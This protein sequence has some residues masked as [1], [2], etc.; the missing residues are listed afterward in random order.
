MSFATNGNTRIY[1]ESYGEGTALVFAH[2][3]GGNASS[4]WQQVPYFADRYQVIAFDH[5]GFGRTICPENEL[6][7]R[8]FVDDLIAVMDQ[9]EISDAILVCQSMGGWTGLGAATTHPERVKALV[10][11]HT[12]GGISNDEIEKALKLTA[13]K[14][15]PVT[16]PFGGWAVAPDF[17]LK[18]RAGSHLYNQIGSFNNQDQRQKLLSSLRDPLDPVNLENF[19]VPTLFITAEQD[20]IFSPEMIQMA[21]ALVP[22]ARVVN[23]GD[24][25]HSSYF[26]T[27]DL[28]NSTVDAFLKELGL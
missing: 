6:E 24:A 17:H 28:F 12:G 23:L 20:Q 5:R 16:D 1:Y 15:Q 25:G 10:M 21:A 13:E 3:A 18:N 26:E 7:R 9:E 2:G 11:S 14:R 8:Y 19:N 22:G 4:W 27:P